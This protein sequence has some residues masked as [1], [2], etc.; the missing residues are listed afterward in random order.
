MQGRK[1]PTVSDTTDKFYQELGKPINALYSNTITDLLFDLHFCVWSPCYKP[2]ENVFCLGIVHA[3]D[4]ILKSYPRPEV[5]LSLK[6]AFT[7]SLGL[8]YD[9]VQRNSTQLLTWVKGK[10]RADMDEAMRGEGESPLAVTVRE[11]QNDDWWRFSVFWGIG[12]A[13]LGELAE[14]DMKDEVSCGGRRKREGK[15]GT[16]LN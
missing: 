15:R 14:I 4:T 16:T 10:N 1:V 3:L 5:A 13:R 9:E 12:L 7:S 2:G 6:R 11:A 8:D